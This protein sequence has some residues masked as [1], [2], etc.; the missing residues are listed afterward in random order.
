[1]ILS[2]TI[3]ITGWLRK[4]HRLFREE[5]R[6]IWDALQEPAPTGQRHAEAELKKFV[7]KLNV[8]EAVEEG[9]LFPTALQYLF[10]TDTRTMDIFQKDH[11][12]LHRKL[13]DLEVQ[14][15]ARTLPLSQMLSAMEFEFTF[16]EHMEQEERVLFPLLEMRLP[17]GIQHELAHR[18]EKTTRRAHVTMSAAAVV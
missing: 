3:T 14:L 15:E 17:V 9:I 1:M 12:I 4:N 5:L 6:H 13:H 11:H 2:D 16:K 7:K 18:A 10:R 8:H